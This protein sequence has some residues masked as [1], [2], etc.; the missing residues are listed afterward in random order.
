MTRMKH[1]IAWKNPHA[2]DESLSAKIIQVG[3][4]ALKFS[5]RIYILHILH[6]Y[7]HMKKINRNQQCFDI[8]NNSILTDRYQVG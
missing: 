6:I 3:I 2:L 5:S 4:D 7:I 1:S 8:G